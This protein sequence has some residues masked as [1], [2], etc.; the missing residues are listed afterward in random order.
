MIWPLLILAFLLSVEAWIRDPLRQVDLE[1]ID[2]HFIRIQIGKP[3]KTYS[4]YLDLEYEGIMMSRTD[5]ELQSD[6]FELRGTERSDIFMLGNY[7]LRLPYRMGSIT[8]ERAVQLSSQQTPVGKIGLG[9]MSPLWRYWNNFSLT[10]KRIR[11]GD[12]EGMGDDVPILLSGQGFC[13]NPDTGTSAGLAISFGTLNLLLPHDLSEEQPT[14]LLV[15]SCAN[16]KACGESVS[17]KVHNQD[18]NLIGGLSFSAVDQSHDGLVHLGRRFF[19]D[20]R[21]FVDWSV[22]TLMIA[23]LA[24]FNRRFSQIYAI[25]I[26]VTLWQWL[27]HR[28][29]Q[30][31]DRL[32]ME[33]ALIFLLE[34]FVV[35]LGVAHWVTNFFIYNWA[36]AVEELLDH[37][38]AVLATIFVHV[39]TLIS[40]ITVLGLL[41]YEH[42]HVA[43]AQSKPYHFVWHLLALINLCLPTLCSSFVQHHHILID[44]SFMLFFATLLAL[45]NGIIFVHACLFGSKKMRTVAAFFLLASYTYLSL[46]NVMPF[47]QILHV[48]EH[49]VMFILQYLLL[50]CLIPTLLIVMYVLRRYVREHPNALVHGESRPTDFISQLLL[51]ES[52]LF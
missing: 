46:C 14:Q 2:G 22:S 36:M 29:H 4:F 17:L 27:L 10:S 11:L 34:C 43:H 39:V 30:G 48:G 42:K 50:F 26:P 38:Q 44:L 33:K 41:Y 13:E 49:V 1:I 19:Y 35:T 18:I 21:L 7:A 25:V 32:E 15:R 3:E 5:T 23:D 51:V 24:E 16:P 31:K 6:T 45:V 12:T 28:L 37:W 52:Q 9:A 8:L 20:I 40:L 47:Y